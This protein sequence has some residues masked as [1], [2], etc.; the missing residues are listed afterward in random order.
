[1]LMVK[2]LGRIRGQG[3]EKARIGMAMLMWISHSE[4]PLK[5]DELCHAFAVEIGSPNLNTDNIPSVGTMLTC[6]Q[7]LVS[8]DKGASAVRLIHFTLQECLRAH[9]EFFGRAH[10]A[11]AETCP[12]YLN[13]RQVKALSAHPSPELHVAPFRIL[14]SIW[15]NA[16]QKGIFRLCETTCTEAI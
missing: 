11:M 3:G 12:S 8:V 9:P 5:V 1:M 10:S 14:L 13:S 7:G 2:L 16:R 4:R 15:G 6:C